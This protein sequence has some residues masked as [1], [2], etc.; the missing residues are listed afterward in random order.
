MCRCSGWALVL[1]LLPVGDSTATPGHMMGVETAHKHSWSLDRCWLGP[2]TSPRV[3]KWVG[4]KSW[5]L[6][7][8]GKESEASDC[9]IS[10]AQEAVF[11][12]CDHSWG[13]GGYWWM[14]TILIGNFLWNMLPPVHP[15]AFQYWCL[16]S[17]AQ[18]CSLSMIQP[19]SSPSRKKKK[20][21]KV[22]FGSAVSYS[23]SRPSLPSLPFFSWIISDSLLRLHFHWWYPCGDPHLQNTY[24]LLFKSS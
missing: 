22:V 19:Q 20:N 15:E 23:S 11:R 8:S 4:G 13:P 9:T 16:L 10:G 24:I 7:A 17:S 2:M 1:R 18:L 12:P 21:F 14:A 3:Q 5:P 6:L